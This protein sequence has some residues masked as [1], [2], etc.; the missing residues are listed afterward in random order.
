MNLRGSKK[1]EITQKDY[2]YENGKLVFTA[3]YLEKRGYCCKNDCRHCPYDAS[4]NP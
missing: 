2:Y 3:Y 1:K 4:K